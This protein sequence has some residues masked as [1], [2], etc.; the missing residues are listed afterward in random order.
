M[1]IA[2]SRLITLA[3]AKSACRSAL[4]VAVGGAMVLGSTAANATTVSLPTPMVD[5]AAANYNA[6]TGVWTDSSGNGDNATQTPGSSAPTLALN[7]TPNGSAA[8]TFNGSQSLN[9]TT[10][11][12]TSTGFTALAFLDP[13]TFSASNVILGIAPNNPNL[14][15]AFE[16]RLNGAK[17]D[18]V[19]AGFVDEGTSNTA[20]SLN[21]WSNINVAVDGSGGTFRLN[22]SV[23]GTCGA[24]SSGPVTG[25]IGASSQDGNFIGNI[26]EIQVYAGALT[27]AQR[28]AVEQQFINAYVTP[29]PEPAPLILLTGGMGL[30]L[31]CKRRKVGA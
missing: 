3:Q 29:V 12:S 14:G 25:V 10:G 5:Y 26:A 17:Q 6:T 18:V 21:S 4:A 11:L 24:W 27:D 31:V 19:S 1:S 23:D 13:T 30:L 22:G 8:V 9:I 28:Q 20:L 15:G 7:A 2:K 16:Y